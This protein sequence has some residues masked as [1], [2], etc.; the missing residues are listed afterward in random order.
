[1]L[2]HTNSRK[3]ACVPQC[4]STCCQVSKRDVQHL[5]HQLGKGKNTISLPEFE[6]LMA[7]RLGG[8]QAASAD[9]VASHMQ[10]A[11]AVLGN[12][13]MSIQASMSSRSIGGSSQDSADSR[14]CLPAESGT[15]L[16]THM[17]KRDG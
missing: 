4:A 3:G 2:P 13:N 5:I 9:E 14:A 6:M 7:R 15:H 17:G 16:S 8:A 11:E 10:G 12:S 1:M